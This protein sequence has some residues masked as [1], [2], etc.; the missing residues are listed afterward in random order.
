MHRHRK[1]KIGERM[2]CFQRKILAG[3]SGM[4]IQIGHSLQRTTLL[5][6][7]KHFIIH[8]C[9][10][11]ARKRYTFPFTTALPA[12]CFASGKSPAIIIHLHLI[13]LQSKKESLFH[14][15]VSHQ[16]C[17]ACL[18]QTKKAKDDFYLTQANRPYIEL[19]VSGK[20]KSPLPLLPPPT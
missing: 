8:R 3:K 13:K 11:H 7:H 16:Q 2:R 18:P 19:I 6:A 15:S 17:K 14:C 20:F 4:N 10:V 12:Q 9:F 1:P 5:D